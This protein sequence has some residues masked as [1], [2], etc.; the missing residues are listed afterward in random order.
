VTDQQQ[1]ERPEGR[2]PE[3][4]GRYQRSIAGGIGSMIVLVAVVLAFVFFRGVFRDND[5]VDVEPVDYLA[6]VGPAQEAGL[7]VVYPPSLPE[8]WTAT[9]VAFDPG[10]RPAWGVGM[11]T[12]DGKFVGVR[13]EDDDL[14]RLLDTYV[15]ENA[16]EGET[17]TVDGA[18]VPEWQE[19]SDSGGDHAYAASIGDQEVLVFGSAPTDDLLTIVKSLTDA[20]V[21]VG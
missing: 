20:P 2:P 13:Q 6:V 21:A 9:S 19:W 1:E 17:I 8:G 18:L 3:R 5:A 4:P 16:V 14:D 11:L 12:D 10:D 7:Q 15:D